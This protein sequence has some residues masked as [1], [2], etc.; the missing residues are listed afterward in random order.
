M[1]GRERLRRGLVLRQVDKLAPEHGFDLAAREPARPQQH[2]PLEAADDGRFQSD[3]RRTAVNDQVD[4]AGEVGFHMLRGRRRDVARHVGRRRDHR[5]A[6]AQ[7]NVARDRVGGN[8]HGDGFESCGGKLG[9]RAIDG[10]GQH[11]RQ[12]ARPE[13][14][15]ELFGAGIEFCDFPRGGKVRHMGDQR[16]ERR[17][18]LGEVEPSNR[19]G[20]GGV[21]AEPVHGF[22]RERDEAPFGEAAR[23]RRRRVGAGQNRSGLGPDCHFHGFSI[24]DF[25]LPGTPCGGAR[26]RL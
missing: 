16:I 9:D 4:L 26:R 24:P 21:G 19:L 5:L 3:V 13:F 14:C 6:E 11:Q 10:A 23:G 18:P 15:G 7:E 20:V 2:R 12:W 1:P 17:P 25:T 22:R 8:A